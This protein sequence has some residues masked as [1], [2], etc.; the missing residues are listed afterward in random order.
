MPLSNKIGVMQGRLLQK[1]EQRYQAHPIGYW[2]EEFLLAQKLGLDCIEF[3]LDFN[4]IHLNPLM[5]DEGIREITKLV[6][7]TGVSVDTICADYFM[8]FPLHSENSLVVLEGKKALS[9]LLHA[10]IELGVTDIVIPCVD[11]SSITDMDKR[12]LFGKRIREILPDFENTGVNLALETDLDPIS[13]K[14]LLHSFDSELIKVNYDIGN[15]ASLGFNVV[16][17]LS[18]YG[19]LISDIHIKDRSL[20]GA[21]IFLGKG[22]AD[23]KLFFEVLGNYN[24]QGPFIMQAYRDDEG[25]GVFEEQ[26]QWIR[27]YLNNENYVS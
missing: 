16:E 10:S 11:K 17:E 3:I 20:R 19:D 21:S 4:D 1:Y 6:N 12:E 23:F 2:Q 22:N 13:F 26:L 24:Y 18:A 8:E 25:V 5:S 15:S 9:N 14:N 7:H 27:P